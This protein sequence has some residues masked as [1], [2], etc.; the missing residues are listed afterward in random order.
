MEKGVIA[1]DGIDCFCGS[2]RSIDGGY[3]VCKS[4]DRAKI[5]SAQKNSSVA[6]RQCVVN[7][8][9]YRQLVLYVS[10]YVASREADFLRIFWRD[11]AI[12]AYLCVV[13]CMV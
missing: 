11:R 6:C 1:Y 2:W 3:I 4:S 9:N 5:Q 12:I 10:E 7:R 8:R 13:R